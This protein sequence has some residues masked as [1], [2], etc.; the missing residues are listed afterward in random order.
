MQILSSESIGSELMQYY[1]ERD[2]RC[3]KELMRLAR[4]MIAKENFLA[5]LGQANYEVT[6]ALYHWVI[7]Q[8]L[9]KLS[10]SIYAL[11]K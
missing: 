2:G 11:S 5:E 4:M 7:Y 9:G 1:E 10:S 6:L 3:T 8:L